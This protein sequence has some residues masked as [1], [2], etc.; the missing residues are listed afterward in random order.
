LLDIS[1]GQTVAGGFETIDLNVDVEALGN[2][3][4][5]DGANLLE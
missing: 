3:F 2:T 1:D 5:K 4:R